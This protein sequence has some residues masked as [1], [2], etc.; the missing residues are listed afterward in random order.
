MTDQEIKLVVGSLLHDV[1]KVIYRTGDGR[2]HSQSGY[3]FLKNEAKFKDPEILNC[4]RYHHSDALK[5]ARIEEDSLAYI[6]YIA[7]NIAS[8]A[9]R[10]K[11]EAEDYGFEVSA[12]LV[13]VFNILNGNRGDYYYSPMMLEEQVNYPQSGKRSF[14]KAFYE[15]VMRK[16]KEMAACWECSREYINSLLT[17][18]EA[19]LTFVPSSTAKS[20]L[21]DISL[22]DHVKLTAA[23]ASCIYQYL[24]QNGTRDYRETLFAGANQFYKEKAFLLYSIDLSGIQSFLYT[25]HPQNALKMLRSRS[26][27]LSIMME[28][29]ID[30][31][32]EM[33][34]LTRANL[35]CTG[36]GHCYLLLPN[37]EPVKRALKSYNQMLNSWL[38]EQYDISLYAGDAYVEASADDLKNVPEGSFAGLF[39]ELERRLGTRK[40]KKYSAQEVSLLNQ[41]KARDNTRE[42][43]VCKR[44]GRTDEEGLCPVCRSLKAFSGDIVN[45]KDRRGRE[46]ADFF[47]VVRERTDR[48]LILPGALFTAGNSAESLYLI[49]ETEEAFRRRILENRESFVRAYSRNRLYIGLNLA[50]NLWVGN[51]TKGQTFE[52]LAGASRGIKRLGVLRA[53]VDNL[54]QAF[55]SGFEGKYQTLSRTATLSRQLTM[56]FQYHINGLLEGRD[57]SIIYSGG[58]DFFLVGAWNE[59]LDLSLELNNRFAQYT[60]HM[61]TLSAG[62]GIYQ[63]KYP[64]SQIAA[65]VG[66]LVDCSK[67]LEGKNAVTLFPDGCVHEVLQED[68]MEI[69]D[70]GTYRWE[71]LDQLI[72]GEK[73]QLLEEFLGQNEEKG[74]AF[75]YRILE[76]IRGRKEAINFARFAYLMAR[77]EP[78]EKAEEAVKKK[79]REFAGK[80]YEWMKS[81]EDS[82]QLKTAIYIYGYDTRGGA[83]DGIE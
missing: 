20:E 74:K 77:L 65:E 25:I 54:G 18:M 57:V 63:S 79:Y 52:E 51:Y 14:D 48:G 50:T 11:K 61:L 13:P 6:T 39:R 23:V 30:S 7:D 53:D 82:R 33:C 46:Q 64:I 16:L 43:R 22:Y 37:T 41:G 66:R 35:I 38:M 12:P 72:L 42:C 56:F 21:A 59:I 68:G 55:L 5:G 49:R 4:V 31:V 58:D 28:H 24:E 1:G 3:D 80:M 71:E 34:D 70:D 17:V 40:T 60:E 29:I 9:D 19:I 8:G 45:T 10:R 67:K 26:F 62:I 69:V 83:E 76:L 81:E 75:L 44:M 32:L 78:G 27:Y 73:H 15:D 2:K 47:V 36:G